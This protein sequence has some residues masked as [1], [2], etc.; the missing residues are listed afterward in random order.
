MIDNERSSEFSW[1]RMVAVMT[2]E[3]IQMRRDRLTFAMMVGVPLLQLILFGFAINT[4]PKHLP[5]ALILGD[6]SA[7]TRAFVRGLEHT[8]YFSIVA[9]PRND[10]EAE[11]LIRENKAL[12]VVSIPPNFTEDLIAGKQ[13]QLLVE[14]D[15][16]DGTAIGSALNAIQALSNT[17]FNRFFQGNLQSL[18]TQPAAFNVVT[19]KKYNPEDITS[20]NIVPGLLGVVLT[21][22]M[23]MITSLAITRENER[24]TM[25][26]L[27]A[28]PVR[29]VEVIIGKIA[30]YIIVG[31]IQVSLIL[32]IAYFVFGVPIRGNVPLLLFCALPFIAANLALGLTFSSIAKNQL[33]SVQMSFFFFLPS[34]LLS[35][36]MFP[37]FGMPRWA[38]WIGEVLPLTHFIRIARGILLKGN[39]IQQALTDL[40]PITLFMVLVIT[41][42]VKRY[43]Q[44]LD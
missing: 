14:A 1:F 29:P 25:E 13:P 9:K 32:S 36:F 41:L 40:W 38:Q 43:R 39:G 10:Q 23:V 27:L 37:F 5:T 17:V 26:S 34:L 7:Y 30:P 16:T 44:T 12:F 15:A 42:G 31:Y 21:M 11:A 8:D 4:N 22:T 2:K 19:H 24:G 18:Q 33:Q 35:G 20:F 28:T 3:F 6:N